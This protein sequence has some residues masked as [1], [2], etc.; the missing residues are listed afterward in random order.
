MPHTGAMS[1]ASVAETEIAKKAM[2][3]PPGTFRHTVLLAAKRF[4]STWAE[5]GK[6]LVSVRD[7]AKF[8]EWGYPTF[9]AYCLKEL[10]IKKQTALKLT[11]SFSFLAKHE[12][13][14]EL[15]AQEFPEKAPA[16]EV[17][18]VLADAEE[19]GQLSPTE[20]KS[21]RDSI[22]SPEK[23]PTELKKEFTERFP[24]PPPEPPSDSLQV[25]KL[26]SMARK[27]ASELAGC[28][29]IPNAVAERAAALADDVEELASGVTD[30]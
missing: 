14:E 13:E 6:L 19:R 12:D 28:R 9:E 22:W 23:S 15:K 1:A 24:K 30:A 10:H 25:R 8:E 27:L 5:L 7:E 18:E 3:V 2:S 16:F 29:K 21:L 11:R 26:A 4:K 17:I 20:Y